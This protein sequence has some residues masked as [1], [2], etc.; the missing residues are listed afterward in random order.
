MAG[1]DRG[2]DLGMRVLDTM[3]S[4]LSFD[5]ISDDLPN[6]SPPCFAIFMD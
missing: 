5:L 2:M 1:H 3:L 6:P 4:K